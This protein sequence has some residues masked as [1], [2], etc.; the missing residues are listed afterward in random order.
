[1]RSD[2][3]RFAESLCSLLSVTDEDG[4]TREGKGQMRNLSKRQRVLRGLT[5]VWYMLAFVFWVM[6]MFAP[7]RDLLFE[8]VFYTYSFFLS[9]ALH[10]Y[11]PERKV[12]VAVKVI[13]VVMVL[14]LAVR[15][16]L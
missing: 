2:F 4:F 8:V 9:L 7:D 5:I 16:I 6:L 12:P 3:A 15:L 1:M 13:F 11:D 14:L 10:K